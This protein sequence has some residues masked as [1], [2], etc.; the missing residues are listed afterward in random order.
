MQQGEDVDRLW[1]AA[2]IANRGE[3]APA[4]IVERFRPKSPPVRTQAAIDAECLATAKLY[5]AKERDGGLGAAALATLFAR[6]AA[7]MWV[8]MPGAGEAQAQDAAWMLIKE[9]REKVRA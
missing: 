9:L 3:E 6:V 7:L 5:I 1:A 8:L 2:I 4:L